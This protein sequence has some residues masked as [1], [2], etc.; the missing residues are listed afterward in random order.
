MPWFVCLCRMNIHWT[1][2]HFYVSFIISI[3]YF[4]IR[5]VYI[6]LRD[7]N[8][9]TLGKKLK[10]Y[11]N[12]PSFRL[13]CFS[14]SF[15]KI[16]EVKYSLSFTLRYSFHSSRGTQKCPNPLLLHSCFFPKFSTLMQTES[17][18]EMV[19]LSSCVMC[20]Q[21]RPCLCGT[22]LPS[23]LT[24]NLSTRQASFPFVLAWCWVTSQQNPEGET[25]ISEAMPVMEDLW[26][27][28][29]DGSREMLLSRT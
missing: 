26:W 28:A 21:S 22:M 2:T 20:L 17:A 5:D 19:A 16:K 18:V 7:T 8:M 9:S 11:L 6:T 27:N 3:T 24:G 23:Y 29:C 12:F 25:M 10:V 1:H 15:A 13:T 4:C 14:C